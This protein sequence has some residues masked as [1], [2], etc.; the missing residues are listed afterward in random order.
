MKVIDASGPIVE[1]LLNGVTLKTRGAASALAT[2]VSRA[3]NGG[4]VLVS[5]W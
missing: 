1:S 5:I 4:S 3:S 2:I